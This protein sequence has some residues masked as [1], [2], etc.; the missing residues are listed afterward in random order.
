MDIIII[1]LILSLLTWAFSMA[2]KKNRDRKNAKEEF[3]DAVY[4]GLG[5][6]VIYLIIFVIFV[7]VAGLLIVISL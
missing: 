5:A 6:G 7:V 3:K 4:G 2:F 1:F